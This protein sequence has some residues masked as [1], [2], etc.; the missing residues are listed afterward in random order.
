MNFTKL[1]Q[2]VKEQFCFKGFALAS[3]NDLP[4]EVIVILK[5]TGKTATCPTCKRQRQHI[6]CLYKREV[7]DIDFRKKCIIIFPQAK[8]KC[9]CGY[10]GIEQLDFVDKHSLCTK[11][12]E[13]YVFLLCKNMSIKDAAQLCKLNWK[14]VKNIDKKHLRQL[15]I[16]LSERNPKRIGIDEISYEKGHKYLSVVRDLDLKR[17]IWID[18][19]RKKETMDGFFSELGEEKAKRIKVAV[20]DMWDPYIA[21]VAENCP[22]AEIIF[23]KFHISKKVNEALDSIRKKEFSKADAQE[24]KNMKRKRFLIL[25]R[26]KR[27]NDEQKETVDD[28]KRINASLYEAYLLKEQVLDI[29]EEKNV[30]GALVRLGKW[31]ANVER[32]GID[33]YQNIIN[34]I[35]NYWYGIVNYFKYRHT[36]AASEGFNNKINVIKRRAYGFRDLEY[37]KLK[38]LQSCGW[39]SS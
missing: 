15:V 12:L 16:P 35:R 9:T 38:I 17:V 34:T 29:F 26:Q 30:H 22:D 18:R 11:R 27:L 6:E 19:G 24:R 23:D 32:L 8:I 5:R 37:L 10:R 21:S 3:F 4:E 13:E 1:H 25:S 36:N 2:F 14:T 20:M 7:R 33:A 28:L 31:I 39:R